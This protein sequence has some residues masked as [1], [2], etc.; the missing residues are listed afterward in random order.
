[1]RGRFSVGG[2]RLLRAQRRASG[3]RSHSGAVAALDPYVDPLPFA[4][5]LAPRTLNLPLAA[6]LFALPRESC[7]VSSV[8]LRKLL[9][10]A[11]KSSK[12]SRFSRRT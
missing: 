2:R 6:R 4:L 10:Q 9:V 3:L 8:S 12:I 7:L 11:L 1:V 5:S